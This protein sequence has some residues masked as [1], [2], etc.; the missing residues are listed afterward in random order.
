MTKRKGAGRLKWILLLLVLCGGAWALYGATLRGPN[1]AIEITS[2]RPAIGPGTRVHASFAAERWG[3]GRIRLVFE[4]GSCR[5]V[6]AEQTL[7][8]PSA[9]DLLAAAS[10][11]ARAELSAEVGRQSVE[12]LAEGSA[13]I[14]AEAERMSGP[15][16]GEKW[17]R[18]SVELPVRLRPPSIQVLST[19]HYVTQ[20]GSGAVAF[21]V[22]ET[23]V[24][25]GVRVGER[26]IPSYPHP[27][28]G[29]GHRVV[30][31]GVPWD[32]DSAKEIRLFAE[33]DAGNR[34][35][36]AFIFGRQFRRRAPRKDVIRLPDSFL[37]RVVPSIEGQTPRLD[38]SG[39]LIERYLRINQQLRV[40]NRR[41]VAELAEKSAGEALWDGPFLQLPNSARRAGFAERRTYLY[42]G[43]VVDH[44]THLGLDLASVA[45]ADVPAPNR[46]RVLFAGYLGIYGN[47]VILDHGLGLLSLSAHLSRVAVSVGD[48]VDKGQTVGASGATG[49]AGGDHLHLGLF[50]GGIAVSPMEWLDPRWIRNRIEPVLAH[51]EARETATGK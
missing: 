43:R 35:E 32:M 6:L 2:D 41:T 19:A 27:R 39:S 26:D 17:S 18:I 45:H 22:S 25:S 5:K 47:V 23:A 37:E 14:L 49:L 16:R 8:R 48:L 12:C 42:R 40:A 15:L 33:D 20:G 24:R 13:T 29:T 21:H 31:F 38:T 7:S 44:Q 3:L 46:G 10:A 11:G 28:G 9:F 36:A 4:Q 1:V 34:A 51:G 50:A 30:L